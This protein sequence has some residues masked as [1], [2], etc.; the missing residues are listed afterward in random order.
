MKRLLR[1]QLVQGLWVEQTYD[2]ARARLT[3]PSMCPYSSCRLGFADLL[4]QTLGGSFASTQVLL[5]SL[6]ECM[7]WDCQMQTCG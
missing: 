4:N 6:Y 1:R 3:S 7:V 5:L 2:K